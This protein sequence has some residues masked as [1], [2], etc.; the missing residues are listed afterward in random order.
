MPIGIQN[1][2]FITL[3]DAA[4]R[5]FAFARR[6]NA[7]GDR[8][9][10]EQLCSN[11]LQVQDNFSDVLFHSFNGA[12]LMHN[13]IDLHTGNSNAGKRREKDTP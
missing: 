13:A 5:H 1:L 7:G 9:I 11:S 10:G 8:T 3:L 4:S 12:E 2:D 6:L